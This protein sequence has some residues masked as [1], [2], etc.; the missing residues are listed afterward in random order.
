MRLW[1]L[2]ISCQA[3][4]VLFSWLNH[5]SSCQGENENKWGQ[6][7]N[8]NPSCHWFTPISPRVHAATPPSC[9]DIW[10][11]CAHVDMCVTVSRERQIREWNTTRGVWDDPEGYSRG[12]AAHV[13]TSG[14]W[15][16]LWSLLIA[17][18]NKATN[19]PVPLRGGGGRKTHNGGRRLVRM[20]ER[21][22]SLLP[23]TPDQYLITEGHFFFYFFFF[24]PLLL[25]GAERPA[26][27]W[28]AGGLTNRTLNWDER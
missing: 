14:G 13:D 15:G 6:T 26:R 9:I 4:Y 21:S 28:A 7:R 8:R 25:L 23:W 2:S 12:R 11:F 18:D 19:Q 17:S 1:Q 10:V 20:R 24:C 16:G 22:P 3:L 5:F 27:T